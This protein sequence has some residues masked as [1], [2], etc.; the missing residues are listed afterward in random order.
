MKK[1]K[2]VVDAAVAYVGRRTVS[3]WGEAETGEEEHS[4]DL[5]KKPYDDILN[6]VYS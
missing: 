6:L 5:Y 2:V 3:E 4:K 1:Y